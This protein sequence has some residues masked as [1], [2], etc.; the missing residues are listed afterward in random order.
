MLKIFCR[1]QWESV[2]KYYHIFWNSKNSIHHPSSGWELIICSCIDFFFLI[3]GG[4][5]K[6][7]KYYANTEFVKTD[8]S[9]MCVLEGF[10]ILSDRAETASHSD[11][12][13]SKWCIL[14]VCVSKVNSNYF[15]AVATLLPVCLAE[16]MQ[17]SLILHFSL[18]FFPVLSTTISLSP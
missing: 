13:H 17:S 16:T 8:D 7:T 9:N 4:Q 10:C 12:L 6:K 18:S 11:G 2:C 14:Y 5:N 15:A 1:P 3:V